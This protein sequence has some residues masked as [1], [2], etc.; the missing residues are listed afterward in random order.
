L[1]SSRGKPRRDKSPSDLEADDEN[2]HDSLN[3][4][5]S[6]T[7]SNLSLT[8]TG[9]T[10]GA[11]ER[12]RTAS[13][14]LNDSNTPV[15]RPTTPTGNFDG[16]NPNRFFLTA[17]WFIKIGEPIEEDFTR[18]VEENKQ[19]H[20]MLEEKD[21]RIHLLEFKVAQLMKDTRTISEEN[22]RYQKENNT[23]VRALSALTAKEKTT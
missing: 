18:V 16:L 7:G 2:D 8:T 11:I 3:Q 4:S 19:F 12:T 10:S 9:A 6:E 5:A 1:S 13:T 21:R 15:G 23:L 14:S 20:S 17:S 22:A